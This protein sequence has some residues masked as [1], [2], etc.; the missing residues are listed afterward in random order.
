M[1]ALADARALDAVAA[2]LA[3]R[4]RREEAAYGQG[5]RPPDTLWD[6]LQRTGA[7][8]AQL[9]VEEGLD[10]EACRL[11]GLFHDAGKFYGAALHADDVPEERRSVEILRELAAGRTLSSA[12][13]DEVADA[14]LQLYRDDPEPSL[15]GRVLF[16]ADNLDKLGPIGV[17][18]YFTKRG[19]RGKGLSA[20]RA[21]ELTVELTYARHAAASMRT[22]AGRRL[23]EALAP[24]TEAFFVSLLEHMRRVGLAEVT[25]EEVDFD[26]LALVVA[27]PAA[28]PCGGSLTRR[29]FQVPGLKCS[30]VHLAHDCAACGAQ[31]EVK[32][33]RPRLASAE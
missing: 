6:H 26:G 32:F 25:L 16:D 12:T 3:E 24:Q 10:P 2:E 5:P 31:R 1:R 7:L 27:A 8:A 11:A 15:L 33:C 22:A 23:A 28:C 9:G 18:N 30:E 4:V 17:A 19:L 29:L 20:D 14:I 21:D 13:V